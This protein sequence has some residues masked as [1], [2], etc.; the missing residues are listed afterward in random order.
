[1]EVL[2]HKGPP[3]IFSD[4]SLMPYRRD[5]AL[6]LADMLRPRRGDLAHALE[7]LT[8]RPLQLGSPLKPLEAPRL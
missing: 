6:R 5:E 2:G 1:M 3:A 7:L 8:L 4:F